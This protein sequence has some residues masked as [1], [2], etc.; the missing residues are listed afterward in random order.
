MRRA[1]ARG[2]RFASGD[3]PGLLPLPDDTLA[4]LGE[5]RP[6]ETPAGLLERADELERLSGLIDGA[7]HGAGGILVVEGEAGIGKTRLLEAAREAAR[8]AGLTVLRAR[9]AELER[10]FAHGVMRQL[11]ERELRDASSASRDDL[12]AG[13]AAP[14]KAA[15]GLGDAGPPGG[16]EARFLVQHAFYWLTVN[17][18][19]RAPLLLCVDDAHWADD[20][21]WGSLV[22]LAHR[23]EDL[24]VSVVIGW[25]TGEPGAPVQALDALR[26]GPSVQSV[27]PAALS[28]EACEIVVR[29]AL[30][31]DVDP[32]FAH[33][34][35]RASGG[36]PF[37]LG[38][39]M[40][41]LGAEHLQPT[42]EAI[43]RLEVLSPETV[44]RSVLVR[45]GRLGPAASELA[46]AVAVLGHEAST[47]TVPD[48]A[49]LTFP[50]ASS[51]IAALQEAGILD[52]GSALRFTHP[53]LRTAVYGDISD[54]ARSALHRRAAAALQAEGR[55]DAAAVHLVYCEPEGDPETVAV[56][57]AAA[58]RAADHG[59]SDWSAALLRRALAEPPIDEERPGLF[60]ELGMAEQ[61]AGDPRATEHLENA[62]EL[63]RHDADRDAAARSLMQVL[64][65]EGRMDEG[66]D[67]LERVIA[68]IPADERERRLRLELHLV[69]Q[70]G[71]SVTHAARLAQRLQELVRDSTGET[72]AERAVLA[73]YA[74]KTSHG[75]TLPPAEV[76]GLVRRA[77]ADGRLLEYAGPEEAAVHYC[78]VSLVVVD[79]LDFA[80]EIIERTAEATMARGH[81]AGLQMVHSQRGRVRWLRG[82]LVAAEADLRGAVQTTL[83]TG[84]AMER[85]YAL[86]MLGTVLV[87]RGELDEAEQVFD[88]HGVLHEDPPPV[89][90]SMT[91]LNARA[92]LHLARGRFAEAVR[93]QSMVMEAMRRSGLALSA[94]WI[95]VLVLAL[96]KNG[97]M[98][99]ARAVAA[100]GLE[101]AERSCVDSE[102][103][104]ALAACGVAAG[105][106][107]DLVM[108]E[109][110]GELMENS[111]RPLDRAEVLVDLGAALR[112]ANRR[113]DAREPLRQALDLARASGAYLI[114]RVAEEELRATGA[115]PRRL[116]LSGAD[117]L[118]PSERRVAELVATG[119]TNRAIAQALFV[120]PKTVETHLRAAFRKLDVTGRGQ[121][122]EKLG[123]PGTS[124]TDGTLATV[125]AIDG[126]HSGVP[127]DVIAEQVALHHG[128]EAGADRDCLL[129]AFDGATRAVRCA[130]AISGRGKELGATLRAGLHA[131]EC[132]L[133]DSRITGAA[134]T[135]AVD[136]ALAAQQGEILASATVR[137]LTESSFHHYGPGKPGRFGDTGRE[138]VVH[139]LRDL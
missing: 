45:I 106:A 115:R 82:E 32:R 67:V 24:P 41:T 109:K 18:S 120:T 47:Q 83:L 10:D 74:F 89:I 124:E 72:P 35:R 132:T 139:Q 27:T 36:N 65:F 134:A 59:A 57:R 9:G 98:E 75:R 135:V 136:L 44:S 6:V 90:Q 22:H 128:R 130:A 94:T 92:K 122:A 119:Q 43:E 113:A 88:E 114:A 138:L 97:E 111:P 63:A 86:W 58:Q 5:D 131:G 16:E 21:S 71:G 104:L 12:L 8:D 1:S 95:R 87:L 91:V 15:L 123:M 100:E 29:S 102:I 81:F 79:E 62:L 73:A 33:A 93:D 118:T 64:T 23:L 34:C 78:A 103:G 17:F 70:A 108:L 127:R 85:M 25:R 55:D 48:V 42:A 19:A 126:S 99:R 46:R 38:E 2:C 30:G 66:V 69:A 76:T 50:V 101:T 105:G 61:F 53:I 31:P 116:V 110:A 129:A 84:A 133:E 49:Q 54:R 112:R 77:W 40:A 14:A 11:F 68:G 125:L 137:E 26:Q 52:R 3:D 117:S 20:A 96:V 56:L 51:S 121:I 28:A 37:Y 60:L 39:L 7:V 4:P 80:E 13:A 107:H